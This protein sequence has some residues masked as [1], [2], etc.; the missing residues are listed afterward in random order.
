MAVSPST[1]DFRLF[2]EKAPS[3]YLVI[4]PESDFR[5]AAA[6]DAYL[7]ATMTA[8]EQIVGQPLFKIFPDNPDDPSAD[9]VS[10]LRTSLEKVLERRAMDVMP[11]QRYDVRKPDGEFEVRYWSP[12]NSP[13][14]DES[15]KMIYILHRAEDVTGVARMSEQLETFFKVSLDMLCISSYDGYFKKVNPAFE[16]ILGYKPEEFMAKPYLEHVH[17]DDVEKTALEVK[18]QMEDKQLVL[19]F[20]NRYRC[21]DGS[22]RL[23]SWKSA[24]VGSLM[25]AAA[26]DITDIRASQ[27]ELIEAKERLELANRD[28]K[29]F[30]YSIA[31]DLRAPLRSMIGFSN[32]VLEDEDSRLS[33][34]SK[35]C[36]GKIFRAGQK[37][38]QLIDGL[39]N[40]SQLARRPVVPV[41]VNLSTICREIVQELQSTDPG[42]IVKFEILDDMLAQG[43]VQLLRLVMMNLLGNAWKYTSK[44]G[45]RALIEVG[46]NNQ[47]G[48]PAYF[49][50]DN[51]AG[52]DMKYANKLFGVFQRLHATSEFEG[53][54]IGLATV[55]R[56]IQA[57]GGKI[58][59]RGEEGKGAEF[60][61]TLS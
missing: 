4:L 52:F 26:R 61:F 48:K 24:P 23:L 2:F 60:T 20:E 54:G 8:R 40:L 46:T 13:I 56:I 18:R 43:D 44:I 51:G 14:F 42:R 21:K 19:N 16:H 31:H 3:L 12:S 58:Y 50:R 1:D 57:H 39:L 32:I 15:G 5:I 11:V 37:M 30:S 29:S 47:D 17:P 59:A 36:L 6:S 55:S 53:I 35:E 28:L 7:R 22:F 49:V 38:G 25:Y 33:E 41:A 34:D 45:D 9:G 27:N 10:N